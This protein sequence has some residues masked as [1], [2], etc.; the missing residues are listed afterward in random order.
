[1]YLYYCDPL[2]HAKYRKTETHPVK[3]NTNIWYWRV[4]ANHVFTEAAFVFIEPGDH[5][6]ITLPDGATLQFM[7][8]RCFNTMIG[9][10]FPREDRAD[11]RCECCGFHTEYA[12]AFLTKAPN[13]QLFTNGMCREGDQI[14]RNPPR[15]PFSS[16][17]A[18]R[19][20]TRTSYLRNI[21]NITNTR[22]SDTY[23]ALHNI[24]NAQNSP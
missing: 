4:D 3:V 23:T 24:R 21:R 20:D 9:H 15:C 12:L 2:E 11:W 18:R 8:P 6:D 16:A 19:C 14:F 5:P 7:C 22:Q 17:N 13:C 1:M 10:R